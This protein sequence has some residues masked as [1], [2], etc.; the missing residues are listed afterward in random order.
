MR[1]LLL[2]LCLLLAGYCRLAADQPVPS[3]IKLVPSARIHHDPVHET[4]GT[5]QSQRYPG[6]FWIH[7]DSGDMPRL[8]AIDASGNVLFPKWMA[9][10][11]FVTG[12]PVEGK[13]LYEGLKIESASHIDWESVSLDGDTMYVCDVGNNGNAR[14]DLGV[15]V[16]CEPNPRAVHNTRV[17]KW[18]PIAY[19]DQD[20][21]PPTDVWEFDCEATFVYRHKLYFLTKHRPPFRIGTP[22]TST[23]L[24]RLDS[25]K[26]DEV[27]ELVPVDRHPDLGGWV[28]DAAL[29]AAGKSLA[30]LCASPVQSVWLF[31]TPQEGDQFLSSPAR[32]LVFQDAGQCEGLSFI[33]EDH[34]LLTN[35]EQQLFVLDVRDFQP[36]VTAHP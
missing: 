24:Y 13:Q 17:L 16:L 34:L 25:Q 15:Y 30:V 27:N 35:E 23:K 18:L 32:R 19:P 5:A 14:R 21:F 7:N 28:T 33:D 31:D 4:S 1:R 36:V 2:V 22:V 12:R 10:R 3:G 11:G 29:S 6:V 26:T 20:Q 9:E 8:F